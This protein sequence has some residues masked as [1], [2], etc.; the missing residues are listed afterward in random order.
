MKG[1]LNS[2]IKR[3]RRTD[4]KPSQSGFYLFHPGKPDGKPGLSSQT[5]SIVLSWPAHRGRSCSEASCPSTRLR[6]L[7]L[8]RR[9]TLPVLA[10]CS[11]SR[12]TVGTDTPYTNAIP[13]ASCVFSYASTSKFLASS[14]S[15]F[16]TTM[17]FYHIS[18]LATI[19]ENRSSCGGKFAFCSRLL[20]RTLCMSIEHFSI[21]KVFIFY[22]YFRHCS[23]SCACS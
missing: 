14:C 8:T 23:N 5:H 2:S 10:F 17:L 1:K 3:I 6:P 21:F 12:Y 20:P 13:F 7:L 15:I 19:S 9:F 22:L 4:Q 18:S 11:A 16:L